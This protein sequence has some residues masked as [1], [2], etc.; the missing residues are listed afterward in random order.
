M[1][2]VS[3]RQHFKKEPALEFS[4]RNRKTLHK[5]GSFSCINDILQ[6][7]IKI[8]MRNEEESNV[9]PTD[10]GGTDT[11]SRSRKISRKLDK[12]TEE[13]HSKF[14]GNV[15]RHGLVILA[16][17]KDSKIFL[18]MTTINDCQNTEQRQESKMDFRREVPRQP[19]AYFRVNDCENLWTVVY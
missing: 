7:I 16:F 11:A 12:G 2:S 18:G 1:V 3:V 9:S 13:R 19:T 4:A 8:G 10:Q 17:S 15:E 5:P 6:V 14:C